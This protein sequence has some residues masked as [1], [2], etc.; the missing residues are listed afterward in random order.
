MSEENVFQPNEGQK[1]VFQPD[2]EIYF[3]QEPI[4]QEEVKKLLGEN[5]VGFS[6]ANASATL[7]NR[8]P[9]IGDERA[10]SLFWCW[11]IDIANGYK[12]KTWRDTLTPDERALVETWDALNATKQQQTRAL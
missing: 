9:T 5:V 10:M 3:H 6:N 12:G 2:V 1:N 7:Y 4:S 8:Y 11:S